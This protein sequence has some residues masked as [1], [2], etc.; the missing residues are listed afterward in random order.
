[1]YTHN[2]HTCLLVIITIIATHHLS[3]V[4]TS[5]AAKR[6]WESVCSFSSYCKN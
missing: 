1:M 5:V 2:T 6:F 3:T 4:V